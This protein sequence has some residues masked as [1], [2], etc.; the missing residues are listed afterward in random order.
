M[1]VSQHAYVAFTKHQGQVMRLD[2]GHMKQRQDDVLKSFILQ[3]VT[4]RWN[5]RHSSRK[6]DRIRS[7]LQDPLA[8]TNPILFF[9]ILFSQYTVLRS[10]PENYDSFLQYY[11][12]GNNL[13]GLS[14]AN[15]ISVVTAG[16]AKTTKHALSGSQLGK[17][18]PENR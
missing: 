4:T 17:C 15:E 16:A 9:R 3:D 10:P 7:R 2:G 11:S 6:V 5:A 13:S 14:G 8:E 12:G 18:A 1:F